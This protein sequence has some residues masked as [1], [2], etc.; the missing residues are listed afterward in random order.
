M[1]NL[2]TDP[3][4]IVFEQGRLADEKQKRAKKTGRRK[5]N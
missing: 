1:K 5:I 4:V 2:S 3:F